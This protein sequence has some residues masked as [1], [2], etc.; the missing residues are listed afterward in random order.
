MQ[1]SQCV[2]IQEAPDKLPIF[3]ALE[4][5]LSQGKLSAEEF[6]LLGREFA[7]VEGQINA[8]LQTKN[9][10]HSGVNKPDWVTDE[11]YVCSSVY[12]RFNVHMQDC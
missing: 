3:V 11:V 4:T 8:Q 5:Q 9:D 1:N 6:Q 2:C 10:E 7:S 12:L